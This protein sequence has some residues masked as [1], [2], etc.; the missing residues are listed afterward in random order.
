MIEIKE[1]IMK[2]L[3][4]RYTDTV[5]GKREVL[6]LERQEDEIDLLDIWRAIVKR[7]NLTMS[8]ALVSA[9]VA[10]AGSLLLPKV[11]EG[12]AIVALPKVGITIDET[13]AITSFLVQEVKNG[14]PIDVM[15]ESVIKKVDNITI[16]QISGLVNQFKIVARTKND[17]QYAP[18]VIN[19]IVDYL[20]RNEYVRSRIDIERKAIEANIFE[21]KNTIVTAE[22]TRNE[23][24]RLISTRNPGFNPVD[25]DVRL[26]DLGAKIIG[27]ETNL[28]LMKNYE[29]V[30]GPYVY[31]D[32]V[33]PRVALNTV[34]AGLIGLFVGLLLSFALEINRKEVS[35]HK[36]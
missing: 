15:D 1:L 23:A 34:I 11:Y 5:K 26:N 13:K 9:I 16:E 35:S 18:D 30:S 14:N 32:K 19:K 7:R 24:K 31:K 25:M 6:V 2:S 27:L 4:P 21:T 29:L 20:N 28:L 3:I 12:E 17:P 33:K 10:L 36:G 8:I 22:R